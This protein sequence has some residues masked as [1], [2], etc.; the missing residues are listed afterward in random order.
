V[1]AES[2]LWID[3]FVRIYFCGHSV[4]ETK[5]IMGVPDEDLARIIKD[6]EESTWQR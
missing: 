5:K 6:K 4:A 3:E 2:E 1:D